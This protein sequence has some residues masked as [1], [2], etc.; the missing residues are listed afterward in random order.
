MYNKR[1]PRKKKENLI[2]WKP[3]SNFSVALAKLDSKYIENVLLVGSVKLPRDSDRMNILFFV[4]KK[5]MR[6]KNWPESQI[7]K[8]LSNSY[9]IY[10]KVSPKSQ[11]ELIMVVICMYIF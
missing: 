5:K 3:A 9:K 8:L 10:S 2:K 6:K 11:K 7:Q 4:C 1:V